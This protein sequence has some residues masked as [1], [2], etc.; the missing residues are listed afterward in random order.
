MKP[1][2]LHSLARTE[3]REAIEYYN[4]ARD[5]LGDEFAD[6]VEAALVRIGRQPKASSPYSGGYRRYFLGKRFTYS[7][8]YI[9][10][11]DYVWVASVYHSSREPD[12]WKD[13]T[14]E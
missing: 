12:G 7:I 11:D 10:Y 8:F 4:D 14:P 6:E 5:G 2:R 3:I 13:R 1:V 9:E